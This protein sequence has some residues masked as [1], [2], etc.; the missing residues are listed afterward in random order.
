MQEYGIYSTDPIEELVQS[1]QLSPVIY[2]SVI[3]LYRTVVEWFTPLLTKTHYQG[4]QAVDVTRDP[5]RTGR[6]PVRVQP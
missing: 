5:L 1:R 4:A 6:L 2:S 3:I